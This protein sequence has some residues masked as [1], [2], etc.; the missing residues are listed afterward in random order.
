MLSFSFRDFLLPYIHAPFLSAPS[1]FLTLRY[2]SVGCWFE[3]VLCL[4][5]VGHGLVDFVVSV[6]Y[7]STRFAG[8]SDTLTTLKWCQVSTCR[9]R[10]V[11][12]CSLSLSD[13]R[14]STTYPPRYRYSTQSRFTSTYHFPSSYSSFSSFTWHKTLATI[15]CLDTE[16]YTKITR[17]SSTSLRRDSL[18]QCKTCLFSLSLGSVENLLGILPKRIRKADVMTMSTLLTIRSS[19]ACHTISYTAS[20]DPSLTWMKGAVKTPS[21]FAPS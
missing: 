6:P 10:R 11:V 19:V 14:N 1:P 8:L 16:G 17:F 3:R 13:I 20:W 21:C 9:H 5:S 15:P 2:L 7:V 18:R 4:A 12:Y